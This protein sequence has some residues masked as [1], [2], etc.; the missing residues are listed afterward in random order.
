MVGVGSAKNFFP[1]LRSIPKKNSYS[2]IGAA[3]ESPNTYT[4]FNACTGPRKEILSNQ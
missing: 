2:K 3:I 1:F 4:A